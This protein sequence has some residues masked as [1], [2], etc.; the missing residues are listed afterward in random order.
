MEPQ[1]NLLMSRFPTT[2]I[3]VGLLVIAVHLGGRLD[4]AE[5]APSPAA[6]FTTE[7]ARALVAAD[8][9]V[10]LNHLRDIS[11]EVA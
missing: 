9:D 11:L 7:Q 5:P 1:E 4:G 8:G 3:L 2:M 10:E 6:G